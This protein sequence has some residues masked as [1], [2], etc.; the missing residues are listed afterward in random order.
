M[1]VLGE[2]EGVPGQC[3]AGGQ[4]P[5]DFM[6]TLQG[7]EEHLPFGWGPACFC[8]GLCVSCSSGTRKCSQERSSLR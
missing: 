8:L 6:Q 7:Q 2:P 1:Q 5:T 4:S 3:W